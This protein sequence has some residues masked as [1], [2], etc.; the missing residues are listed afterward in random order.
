MS[1][2][3]ESV[4]DLRKSRRI[5]EQQLRASHGIAPVQTRISQLFLII[6]SIASYSHVWWWIIHI[7]LVCVVGNG[8]IKELEDN[9]SRWDFK[10]DNFLT[11]WGNAQKGH[12]YE[13]VS[14]AETNLPSLFFLILYFCTGKSD[15]RKH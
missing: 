7:W 5:K 12:V 1:L 10:Q 3:K 13:C 9:K 2:P 4:A 6:M 15:R 14:E 8:K 11:S